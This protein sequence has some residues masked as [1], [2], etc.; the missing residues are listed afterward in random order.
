MRQNYDEEYDFNPLSLVKL[1]YKHLDVTLDYISESSD[2]LEP[3]QWEL[4]FWKSP[5]GMNEFD[6]YFD[7]LMNIKILNSDIKEISFSGCNSVNI[8]HCNVDNFIIKGECN[9]VHLSYSIVN[10]I[11]LPNTPPNATPFIIIETTFPFQ[12]EMIENTISQNLKFYPQKISQKYGF[13]LD[14]NIFENGIDFDW[15]VLKEANL[16]VSDGDNKAERMTL[17]YST[18]KSNLLRRNRHQE[19]DDCHYESKEYQRKNYFKDSNT[20]FFSK[21]AKTMFYYIDWIST[22]YGTKPLR[23]FPYSI[24]VILI[25]AFIYFLKP[26]SIENLH[27]IMRLDKL[28]KY[29]LKSLPLEELKKKFASIKVEDIDNKDELINYIFIK[30]KTRKIVKLAKMPILKDRL[31]QLWTCIYFSFCT[32]TTIGVGDWYPRSNF[33]K[34]LVILEGA[35]GW[36]SLGL[37]IT[38]Y[39]NLLLR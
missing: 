21:T 16:N 26:D 38:A 30:L 4:G 22:G 1:P 20:D 3:M 19:A 36:I 2:S 34:L 9:K 6:G 35:L 14:N 31:T 24:I 13:I 32:F 18:L 28:V 8:T 29:K 5:D 33:S 15:Q 37:F 7:K 10:D 12:L 39:G 17:L 23:I 11:E 27:E 25:F